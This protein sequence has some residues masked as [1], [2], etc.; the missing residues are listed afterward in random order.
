M[1]QEPNIIDVQ[2]LHCVCLGKNINN[3]E[4]YFECPDCTN[5]YHFACLGIQSSE[6]KSCP[7]CTLTKNH[8]F[9]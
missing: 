2:F 9:S 1:P 5:L 7:P 8:I 6:A 3:E 4:K